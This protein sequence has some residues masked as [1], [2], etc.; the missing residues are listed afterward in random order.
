[1]THFTLLVILFLDRCILRDP[2]LCQITYNFSKVSICTYSLSPCFS[3]S[4]LAPARTIF[5]LTFFLCIAFIVK[6]ISLCMFVFWWLSF[7]FCHIF[8]KL[9]SKGELIRG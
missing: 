7:A 5:C 6:F 9:S 1:M 2:L 3:P 8:T 4:Q